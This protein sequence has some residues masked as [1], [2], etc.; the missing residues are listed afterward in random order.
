M[1]KLWR[2][3]HPELPTQP[4]FSIQVV[5]SYRD[6]LSQQVGEA[7]RI[8]LR[9]EDVLNSKA[10]FNRCR[11]PRLTINKD[12][13][14]FQTEAKAEIAN[15]EAK[16]EEQDVEFPVAGGSFQDELGDSAL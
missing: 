8:D 6:A 12:D 3:S 9:G 7:V 13:W 10:E 5:G 14:L 1:V 4:Q 2:I 11:L 15:P 16:D